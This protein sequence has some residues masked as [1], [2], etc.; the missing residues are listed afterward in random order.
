MN[1]IDNYV[2]Y[3]VVKK[4]EGIYKLKHDLLVFSYILCPVIVIGILLGLLFSGQTELATLAA[5]ILIPLCPLILLILIPLTYRYVKIEY[6]Y[7]ISS[8]TM[9]VSKIFNKRSRKDWLEII[10]KDM[11]II[12]PYSDIYK[13]RAESDDDIIRRYEAVSSMSH[14]DMYFTI[15][16]NENDEKSILFFEAT[17]KTLKLIHS[18]NRN[19]IIR[20]VSVQ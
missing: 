12:A 20:P 9:T 13:D 19:T 7:R 5:F 11:E 17:G 18:N 3:N 10:I 8:G 2:E 14:P 16:Q 15:F 1:G 4:Y 6:E